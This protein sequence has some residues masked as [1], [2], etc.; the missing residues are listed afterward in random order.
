VNTKETHIPATYG[1]ALIA[2]AALTLGH[3]LH[4]ETGTG[5]VQR[6]LLI[7]DARQLLDTIEETHPDPYL[8][9]GGRIAFHRRFQEILGAIPADGLTATA[10]FELLQPFVASIG[11]SHTG[12][13]ALAH[14][15]TP[16][17]MPFRTRV[18]E[19]YL[20][21]DRVSGL[22]LEPLLGARLVGFE[23]I[24]IKEILQRQAK[25]RGM[26]N[27]YGHIAI[28]R[29]RTLTTREGLSRVLPEWKGDDTIRIEVDLPSE[30]RTN[31]DVILPSAAPK[32]WIG[33]PTRVDMPST[34]ASDVAYSFLDRNRSTAL[35]VIADLMKYREACELWLGEEM[36]QAEEMTRLAY[37]YFHGSPAPEDRESL[38]AGIPSA[39]ETIA[40]LSRQMAAAGTRNLI[41]DLRGNT[42]GNSVMREILIYLLFGDEAM[43]SLDNGY[44]IVKLSKLL[45]EQYP[46][47]SLEMI[48][49]SQPFP[50]V[51]TDI[52]FREEHL[53]QHPKSSNSPDDDLT[54]A[55]SP[56]FWNLYRT[57]EFHEPAS[58]PSRVLVLSSP[59]TFSSG[60][61]VLTG[62]RAMGADIVGTPSAQPGNNFGDVLQFELTNT[63]IGVFV[64]FKQII[65]FPDDPEGGRCLLP[66][67]PLTLDRYRSFAFDPNAEVLLALE[68]LGVD[69]PTTTG[70]V[71]VIQN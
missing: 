50:L 33:V 9:G 36:A 14:S 64:S 15:S 49:Q 29:L 52:D 22:D 11:D 55:S 53:Y 28:F 46:S 27:E 5:L 56:T 40:A 1:V 42:G 18:V 35:L 31:L 3:P 39:T 54:L 25:I 71:E 34:E 41:V 16:I 20:V 23:G 69:P 2:L 32:D 19:R 59:S 38:L 45:F 6:T 62:L 4:A 70:G 10:F 24:P 7:E 47:T 30:G 66:D 26:E 21:V 57:E 13:L 48:N 65:T 58:G 60:F 61:N 68:I 44:E 37:E 17:F 67:H 43:R 51:P 63:G 12:I 8:A